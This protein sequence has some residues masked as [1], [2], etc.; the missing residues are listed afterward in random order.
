M[1]LFLAHLGFY[2]ERYGMYELHTN[3]HIVAKDIKDAKRKRFDDEEFKRLKMHIDGLQEINIVDG[4]EI[5]P[6]KADTTTAE[7][8]R[9]YSHSEIKLLS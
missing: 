3:R 6:V 4:Y 2:D 8:N 5:M 1:K 7:D 9:S